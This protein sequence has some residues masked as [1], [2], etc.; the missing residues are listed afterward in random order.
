VKALRGESR[1]GP[2]IRHEFNTPA[3][4]SGG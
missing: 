4:L 2:Q 1:R 3:R